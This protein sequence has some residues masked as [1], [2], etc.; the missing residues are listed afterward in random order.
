MTHNAAKRPTFKE[1]KEYF[2]K[3]EEKMRADLVAKYGYETPEYGEFDSELRVT[4]S[5][6]PYQSNPKKEKN[7]LADLAQRLKEEKSFN[8][9]NN[10]RKYIHFYRL[11]A[12]IMVKLIKEFNSS[13]YPC[14]KNVYK[15]ILMFLSVS[16][17]IARLATLFKEIQKKKINTPD[18]PISEEEVIKNHMGEF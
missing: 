12:E 7:N 2:A 17:Y 9:I 8:Y 15:Y 3:V 1:M 13:Q 16:G 10:L 5:I 6:S 14:M 4:K 11:K 18:G